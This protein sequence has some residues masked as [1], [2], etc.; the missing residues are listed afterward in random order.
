MRL[1]RVTGAVVC[2]IHHPAYDGRR[3]LM[4]ELLTPEG[5]PTGVEEIAVDHAQAGVGDRVLILQE[6]NGIRQI[7]GKDAGPI[8]DLIVGVVD[9]I[10]HEPTP[11]PSSTQPSTQGAAGE[12]R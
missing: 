6:G 4:C 8:R 11:Q 10:S 9:L 7:L 2:T 5:A 12:A 3:L 1:A